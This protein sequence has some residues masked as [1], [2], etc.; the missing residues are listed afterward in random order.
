MDSGR[1]RLV[2]VL[3]YLSQVLGGLA[4]VRVELDL[5]RVERETVRPVSAAVLGSLL[6][7]VARF[8]GHAQSWKRRAENSARSADRRTRCA[9]TPSAS[10]RRC[11][12]PRHRRMALSKRHRARC[13]TLEG[14][15][16]I[17]RERRGERPCTLRGSSRRDASAAPSP[18]RTRALQPNGGPCG[19]E[20]CRSRRRPRLRRG[21]RCRPPGFR[22]GSS[23]SSWS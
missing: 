15:P 4:A 22:R 16:S 6:A 10:A 21:D 2:V 11:P 19:D 7:D 1:R 13:E 20:R 8:A 17:S 18:D 3:G 23:R 5:V 12:R 14:L 9:A